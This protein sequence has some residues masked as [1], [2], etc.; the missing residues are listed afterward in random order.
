MSIPREHLCGSPA[1]RCIA[2]VPIATPK[3]YAMQQVQ[4]SCDR[5][6]DA[7]KNSDPTLEDPTL[8][9]PLCQLDCT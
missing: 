9:S 5:A 3:N 2:A 6:S 4:G 1:T 8:D 7:Q